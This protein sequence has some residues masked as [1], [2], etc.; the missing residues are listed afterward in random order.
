RPFPADE[1]AN[2]LMH[3]QTQLLTPDVDGI[4]ARLRAAGT[5]FVSPG[6]IELAEDKLGFREGA[7][8]RDPDGHVMQ[9]INQDWSKR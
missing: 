2:D 1:R 3:W 7:L 6:S 4:V 5:P 9:L 8:V